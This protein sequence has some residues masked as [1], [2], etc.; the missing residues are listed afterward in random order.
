MNVGTSVQSKILLSQS[1]TRPLGLL[2]LLR[3]SRGG[4]CCIWRARRCFWRL[5]LLLLLATG[6]ACQ[7]WLAVLLASLAPGG[8]RLLL[9]LPLLLLLTGA[10]LHCVPL[11]PLPRLGIKHLPLVLV[12]RGL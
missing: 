6:A 11:R 3:H 7:P 1:Q 9:L 10:A 5:L 12:L 8:C 4:Q 2:L